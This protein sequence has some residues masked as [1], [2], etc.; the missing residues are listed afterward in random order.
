MTTANHERTDQPGLETA[1]R[2]ELAAAFRWAAR[3]NLHEATANHFSA[4]VSNDGA[5]F[6]LNPRGRHFSQCC[7][8]ATTVCSWSAPASRRRSMN[9]AAS[10]TQNLPTMQHEI[11]Q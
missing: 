5:S 10:L 6:L 1:V 4:A 7:F 9:C 8:S 2:R 11:S 3:L